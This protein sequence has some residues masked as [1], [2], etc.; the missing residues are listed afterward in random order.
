M[1]L[2]MVMA[3][4]MLATATGRLGKYLTILTISSLVVN[5]LLNA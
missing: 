4:E 2:S 1:P 5:H 3:M